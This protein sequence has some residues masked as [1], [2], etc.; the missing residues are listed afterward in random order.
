VTGRLRLQAEIKRTSCFFAA[1]KLCL[2]PMLPTQQ[3]PPVIGT[4][5]KELGCEKNNKILMWDVM[6]DNEKHSP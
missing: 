3:E 5:S 4:P 1:K 6:W 2:Y